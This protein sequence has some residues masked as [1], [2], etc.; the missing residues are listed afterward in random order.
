MMQK[1]DIPLLKNFVYHCITCTKLEYYLLSRRVLVLRK[2]D[3]IRY[4]LN[5]HVLKV[6][7]VR[8]AIKLNSF[9]LTYVTLRT[10]KGQALADFSDPTPLHR[11][12]RPIC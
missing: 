9:D 8:W 2:V 1:L 6:R 7:L 3:I 4:L 12:Q 10:V 11:G 5:R